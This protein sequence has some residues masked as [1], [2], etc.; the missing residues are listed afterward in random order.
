MLK[1]YFKTA[2]R[3]LRKNGFYSWINITGLSIGLA[4]GI[5]ILLWVRDELSF[6]SFH[7]KTA[8]IYRVE[9]FGGTGASR[10]IWEQ[11]V[12]PIGPLA[13]KE[14]PVVLDEVRYSF[15]YFFSMYKYQGKVFGK[16]KAFCVDPS[17]FSVFDF[18]LIKGNPEKPFIDDY[19]IVITE[20]SA[21]KYFGNEDPM[22]KVIIADGTTN[23][24]VSGVIADLP[25]NSSIDMDL[26]MPMSFI[27]RQRQEANHP[28]DNDFS[29]FNYTTF[30]LLKPGTPLT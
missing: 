5:M 12:A 14:L 13:K 6:D 24:T 3:N 2:I 29:N 19:S 10:Q 15:N 11:M 8:D 17:F 9:I 16:E 26:M 1:N 20:K 28:I 18:P 22:G 4:I 30:L 27:A 7:K 21:K 25:F 23:F